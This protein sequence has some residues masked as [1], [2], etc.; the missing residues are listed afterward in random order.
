MARL[1]S[2]AQVDASAID[3][4]SSSRSRTAALVRGVSL[5]SASRVAARWAI[6]PQASAGRAEPKARD[7]TIRQTT[8]P[9]S[10]AAADLTS[11]ARDPSGA[12]LTGFRLNSIPDLLLITTPAQV[13]IRGPD[14][15]DRVAGP[16]VRPPP[17]R[18]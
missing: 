17:A 1:F 4:P 16:A 15:P 10:Q 7:D 14:R 3:S 6:R 11:R 8:N 9:G 13:W 5:V 18:H 2:S 12:E